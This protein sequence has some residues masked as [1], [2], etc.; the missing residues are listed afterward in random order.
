M[1]PV[2]DEALDRVFQRWTL[3]ALAVDQGW[4]GRDSRAKGQQ[5]RAEVVERLAAGATRRRPPDHNNQNDVEDL[6][7]FLSE[8]VDRFFNAEADDNSDVEVAG[9]VLRLYNS[10]RTGDTTF[11][12]QFLEAF[13]ATQGADLSKCQGVNNIQYATQEDELLDTVQGMDL[14]DDGGSSDGES[15]PDGAEAGALMAQDLPMQ[16]GTIQVESRAERR[17]EEPEIDEDG[18]ETVVKGRR[19]PR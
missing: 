13:P 19:R 9:M 7:A 4:G 12:Q 16:D 2:F 8:R 6:A 15:L 1:V 11:A 3:L 17:H 14:D 10:C 5:L 18:F